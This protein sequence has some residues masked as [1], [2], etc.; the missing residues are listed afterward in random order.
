MMFD[1]M[2]DLIPGFNLTKETIPQGMSSLHY[3]LDLKIIIEDSSLHPGEFMVLS[4]LELFIR[5]QR[6]IVFVASA[7]SFDH[8]SATMK[9]LV[10]TCPLTYVLGYQPHY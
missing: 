9:K 7:N 4:L 2:Q 3:I 10:N 8:Y 6:K 5:A 1:A